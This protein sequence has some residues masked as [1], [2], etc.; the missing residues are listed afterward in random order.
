MQPGFV[1]EAGR[2]RHVVAF[3]LQSQTT[4]AS[5][6]IVTTWSSV[7]TGVRADV[8]SKSAREAFRAGRTEGLR[9]Y[10]ATIRYRSD[11]GNNHRMIWQGRT[12]D[13]QGV[14]NLDRRQR[15]LTLY[16]L[17]HNADGA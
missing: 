3:E 11:I 9:N 5:G 2:L 17:E 13:V 15:Y 8:T 7:A 16:L 4:D 12:F 10:E 6:N 14:L 1:L